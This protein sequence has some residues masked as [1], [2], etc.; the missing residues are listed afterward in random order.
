[1]SKY[2]TDKHA[3]AN[4]TCA[5]VGPI[6]PHWSNSLLFVLSSQG[7]VFPRD[8]GADS[9]WAASVSPHIHPARTSQGAARDVG[10]DLSRVA[11]SYLA[12]RSCRKRIGCARQRPERGIMALAQM[13]A[14]VTGRGAYLT[15]KHGRQILKYRHARRVHNPAIVFGSRDDAPNW[16]QDVPMFPHITT[17]GPR[18]FHDRSAVHALPPRPSTH[19]SHP[20]P[21][22]YERTL[23]LRN[24]SEGT[25]CKQTVA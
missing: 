6:S 2:R 8:Q 4:D 15:G 7:S 20:A 17:R 21:V 9:C 23:G 22:I 5:Q 1:M 19:W 24:R 11:G 12:L 3:P 16:W 18:S 25:R 13:L 14:Q 10:H